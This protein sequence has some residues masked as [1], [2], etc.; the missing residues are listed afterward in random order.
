[1]TLRL[2]QVADPQYLIDLK[3]RVLACSE[4]MK[5]IDKSKKS[6]MVQQMQREKTLSRELE[7]DEAEQWAEVTT[8]QSQFAALETK[9][10]ELNALI[11]TRAQSLQDKAVRLVNAKCEWKTLQDDAKTFSIPT[12]MSLTGA[13]SALQLKHDELRRKKSELVKNG[14]LIAGRNKVSLHNSV[15]KVAQLK[16]QIGNLAE[17]LQRKNE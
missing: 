5:K 9:A 13:G 16:Q 17:R 7:K 11:Q 8:M 2:Q 4:R 12:I 15:D 10:K 1:M 3:E 14:E 6:L